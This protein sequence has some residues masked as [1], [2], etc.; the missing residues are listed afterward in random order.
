MGRITISTNKGLIAV[1]LLGV[2]RLVVWPVSLLEGFLGNIKG[3]GIS[4]ITGL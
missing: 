4:I 3:R 2:I 1:L